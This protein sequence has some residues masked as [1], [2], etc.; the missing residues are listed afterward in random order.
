M[1]YTIYITTSA[2]NNIEEAVKYYTSKV[3]DLGFKFTDD[4]DNNL[5]SIAQNPYAFA[6]RYKSVRDKLLKTFPYLILY[7]INSTALSVE[8]LRLFNTYQ[9]PF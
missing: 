5:Q 8:V 6:E 4:V 3:S 1:A 9:N 7:K 2:I